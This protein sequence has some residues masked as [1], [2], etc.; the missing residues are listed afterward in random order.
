MSNPNGLSSQVSLHHTTGDD[1]NNLVATDT[2]PVKAKASTTTPNQHPGA[3]GYTTPARCAQL[4][5]EM[6]DCSLEIDTKV[7]MKDLVPGPDPTLKDYTQFEQ[8]MK[9][10]L[11]ISKEVEMYPHIVSSCSDYIL[12]DVL[13]C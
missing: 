6:D 2:T 12:N 9:K 1:R 5:I 8:F 11:D 10:K 7:F 3:L 13:T 4:S